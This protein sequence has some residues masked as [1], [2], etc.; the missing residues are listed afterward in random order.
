MSCVASAVEFPNL[1]NGGTPTHICKSASH[2]TLYRV[3]KGVAQQYEIEQC[4]HAQ[5]C[6]INGAFKCV[7]HPNCLCCM[8]TIGE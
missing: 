3:L 5:L 4:H 6:A 1:A 7:L 2:V 8:C